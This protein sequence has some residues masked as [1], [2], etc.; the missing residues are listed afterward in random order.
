MFTSLAGALAEQSQQADD[1][2][3]LSRPD[4]SGFMFLRRA[5]C[6]DVVDPDFGS[7]VE[8]VVLHLYI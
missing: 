2:T 5:C 3:M 7:V 1:S 8:L 4:A 6:S